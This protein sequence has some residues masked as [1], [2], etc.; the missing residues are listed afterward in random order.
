M[1]ELTVDILFRAG[2]AIVIRGER[3]AHHEHE[4]SVRAVVSGAALDEDGLVCDFHEV[5]GALRALV[6]PF[7]G[8]SLNETPPFDRINPTAERV[9]EHIARGLVERLP[10]GVRFESVRVGESPG[11]YATVRGLGPSAG[12]VRPARRAMERGRA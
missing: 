10:A 2:H 7:E 6:A 11:C 4:W 1:I 12:V 3:E 8:R 5:E 9:A